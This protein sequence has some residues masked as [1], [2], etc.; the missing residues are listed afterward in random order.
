MLLA[1]V[2]SCRKRSV[3]FLQ[4]IP[5]FWVAQDEASLSQLKLP[6]SPG[7]AAC[8]NK[9]PGFPCPPQTGPLN[10]YF[11]GLKSPSWHRNQWFRGKDPPVLFMHFSTNRLFSSKAFSIIQPKNRASNAWKLWGHSSNRDEPI[12]IELHS[13]TALKELASHHSW[14]PLQVLVKDTFD[15]LSL[16]TSIDDATK[17]PLKKWQMLFYMPCCKSQ[18]PWRR[19]SSQWSI[20]QPQNLL[21][22]GL[23]DGLVLCSRRLAIKKFKRMCPAIRLSKR[24]NAFHSKRGI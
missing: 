22:F 6:G 23:V 3:I 19:C 16:K 12:C 4:H 11:D 8:S 1:T 18:W 17:K 20:I 15:H 21:L 5:A 10:P 13:H 24:I 2:G 14:P 9:Q 7:C